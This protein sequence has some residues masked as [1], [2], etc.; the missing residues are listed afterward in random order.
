[1]P[2]LFSRSRILSHNDILF[3]VNRKHIMIL[4]SNSL[5]NLPVEIPTYDHDENDN[6]ILHFGVGAFHRAHQAAYL[7]QLKNKHS[8]QWTIWGVGLLSTDRETNTF[9]HDQNGLYTLVTASSEG[10]KAR[11]V[12]SISR[13][14]YAPDNADSILEALKDQRVKIVS[15]TITEGGY[16]IANSAIADGFQDPLVA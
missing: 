5:H 6:A 11:I 14:F 1:M 2:T 15:L 10:Y 9:F 3:S 4:T 7:D 12:G 16:S 8:S 13:Y